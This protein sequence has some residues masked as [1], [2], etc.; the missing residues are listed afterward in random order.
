MLA[1]ITNCSE[2]PNLASKECKII[3]AIFTSKESS[4]AFE[5]YDVN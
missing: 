4:A 3:L 1:R 2:H 5:P